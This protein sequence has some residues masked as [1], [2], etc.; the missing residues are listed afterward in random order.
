MK[1]GIITLPLHTNY[2]GILQAYA[3][4]TV[5][6]QMGHSVDVLNKER[7]RHISPLKLPIKVAKRFIKKYVLHKKAFLFEEHYYNKTYPIIS[8]YTQPFIDK[9]IHSRIVN[10]LTVIKEG[11]YDALI[12]GSDQIW[13]PSYYP[14][15]ENA[16]FSFAKNWKQVKRIAY[17]PSFGTDSWKYT[18]QQTGYCKELIKKFDLVT[19]RENDAVALCE[20]YLDAKATH[21]LDPTMLLDVNDYE[22]IITGSDNICPQ[23]PILLSYVLD[24]SART[25]SIIQQLSKAKRLTPFYV[26][27]KVEDF[28][29]PLNERIQKPVEQ[30][31]NG[32]KHADFVITDSFHACVFSIIFNKPFVVLGNKD[33]GMSRFTSLLNLFGL[34]NRLVTDMSQIETLG[35]IDWKAVNNIRETLKK[36][37]LHLLQVH[38]K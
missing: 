21:V 18:P 7:K 33:R 17:A 27:S 5:L 20:K 29:A 19:V 30:W 26:S 23:Q 14:N 9:Y 10:D 16:Y 35:D 1:I 15:I 37:C 4:Q 38:L 6:E 32:F 3:L 31:L 34:E 11:E 28:Y 2:G 22:A 12:V 24:A 8:K 25:T 13:R 36:Q